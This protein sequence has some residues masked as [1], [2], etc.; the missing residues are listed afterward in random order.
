MTG[1][2]EEGS[3]SG[4]NGGWRRRQ[5]RGFRI[6]LLATLVAAWA[7]ACGDGGTGTEPEPNRTPTAQGV[8]PPQTII[9]GESAT[10]NVASYF[11]D[12]DGDALSYTAATSN[13]DVAGVSA[14]GSTVTV[15][16]VAVGSATLTVTAR[17]PGG[18]TATQSA[19]VTVE[20]AN[21]TPLA[22][23]SIP[24]QAITAGQT[25][26]LNVSPFFSDPDGDAL[27]YGATSSDTSVATVSVSGSTLTVSAVAAGTTTITATATDPGGLSA[28]LSATTTVAPANRAPS[29]VGSVPAETMTAGESAVINLASFFT[30]PDNDALRY[31]ATSDNTDVATTSVSGSDVT[32]AGE[33]PGT[34]TI[35]VTATDPAGLSATQ[36]FGVTVTGGG[37][38]GTSRTYQT[39]ETIVT[40]PTG[41]WFPDQLRGGVSFQISSGQALIRFQQNGYIVE[42]DIRYTCIS[43]GGC[44]I[45]GRTVT[46]GSVRATT[47]DGGGGGGGGTNRAPEAVGTISDQEV[48]LGRS[49]V[50]SLTPYF[51]DPDGDRL[52]YSFAT[53]NSLV[54]TA[55]SQGTQAVR[56][57]GHVDGTVTI[58]VTAT[59]P[60]GLSATQSFEV[61][62][63]AAGGGGSQALTGEITLCIAEQIFPGSSSFS[64]TIGGT[65]TA[66]RDVTFVQVEGWANFTRVGFDSL[67]RMSAGESKSFSIF[68]VVSLTGTT[69]VCSIDVEYRAV[70]SPA[71]QRVGKGASS[72]HS[73]DLS[74]A[75][76]AAP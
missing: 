62:V 59:D 19:S 31:T 51:N 6:A 34:A 36:T 7:A 11:N 68:R 57:R 42:G 48:G 26:T 75:G 70:S 67:G 52:D 5:W 49:I 12:P 15:V 25:I 72:L 71:Q 74:R 2:D 4:S 24:P 73:L 45:E 40:L 9:A 30:D 17:D 8:I 21:R 39:G 61:T 10:V 50:V 1:R 38:G 43:T 66:H 60:G 33:A 37:G 22:V 55:S 35:T 56:I 41:V 27:A 14:S 69:L 54:A 23:G 58:T 46:Q 63:E 3:R 47:G 53:S 13:A 18:L 44:R 76:A 20:P 64:V 16:A 29:V 28:S 65:L 32:V